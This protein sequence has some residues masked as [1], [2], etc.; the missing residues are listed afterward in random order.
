MTW[1]SQDCG[2]SQLPAAGP[3]K[4]SYCSPALCSLIAARLAAQAPGQMLSCLHLEL[5]KTGTGRVRYAGHRGPIGSAP[6]SDL[7][8]RHS[9]VAERGYFAQVLFHGW[10]QVFSGACQNTGLKYTEETRVLRQVNTSSNANQSLSNTSFF[11]FWKMNYHKPIFW[12][13]FNVFRCNRKPLHGARLS[14]HKIFHSCAWSGK[15]QNVKPGHQAAP[16]KDGL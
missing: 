8:L 16:A 11:F 5:A 9:L 7:K 15:T 3:R 13:C 1:V 4:S 10:T 12:S 6:Q 2:S 14:V